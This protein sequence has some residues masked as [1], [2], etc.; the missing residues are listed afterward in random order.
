MFIFSDV[1]SD[2]QKSPLPSEGFWEGGLVKGAL[3]LVS[4][5]RGFGPQAWS[6]ITGG[7]PGPAV[8]MQPLSFS[9]K[10]VVDDK[11]EFVLAHVL[12]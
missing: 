11:A 12:F 3:A 2:L 9:R 6:L 10:R 1:L 4:E 7:N 8:G 5:S